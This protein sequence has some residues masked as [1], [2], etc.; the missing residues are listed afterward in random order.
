MK[1]RNKRAQE[2]ST[3]A[4]VLIVLAVIVL[5]V[6]ALGFTLGWEKIAPWLS[7]DNNI[8]DIVTQCQVACSTQNTYDYCTKLRE[9]K[10]KDDEGKEK[11]I[12]GSCDFLSSDAKK[13]Y[14]IEKCPSISC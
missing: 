3:N 5:A 6:L 13:V 14:G 10:V 1:K 7:T 9:L 11:V 2:M 12:S 4:I 8:Q